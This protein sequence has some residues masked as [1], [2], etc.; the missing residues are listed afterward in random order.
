MVVEKTVKLSEL[1]E[2]EDNPRTISDKALAELAQSIEEFPE[3]L[4]A[5]P[6][7]VNE[8]NQV[9]GGSQRLKAL[10]KLGRTE[11]VVKVVDWDDAK[12]REFMI[13][14]NTEKGEWDYNELL[15]TW[16]TED[17]SKWGVSVGTWNP[18]LNP[19]Q[20][21]ERI[22]QG[23]VDKKRAELEGKFTGRGTSEQ[24]LEI[25][26]QSCGETYYADK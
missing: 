26:C 20:E 16:K 8:L 13:K 1:T 14:D 25:K 15:N 2:H 23:D 9:I 21:S 4:E 12:Q 3:M 17:L 22:T 19:E 24:Y 10:E 6:I 5:R 18:V 11:A 7:V